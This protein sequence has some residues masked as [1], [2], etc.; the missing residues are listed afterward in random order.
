MKLGY[1]AYYFQ[2]ISCLKLWTGKI[3]GQWMMESAY[4]ISSTGAF[5]SGEL[6]RLTEF[7]CIN[8][9]ADT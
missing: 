5:C 6:K 3:D 1:L 4:T 7:C 8:S 9:F 2:S